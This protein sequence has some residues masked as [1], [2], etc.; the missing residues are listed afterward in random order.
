MTMILALALTL[1]APAAESAPQAPVAKTVAPAAAP[2]QTPDAEQAVPRT[3]PSEAEWKEQKQRV[4]GDSVVARMD[5]AQTQLASMPVEWVTGVAHGA[6]EAS[7]DHP[8][9]QVAEVAHLVDADKLWW[10][11]TDNAVAHYSKKHPY[12]DGRW[13]QQV[14]RSNYHLTH[15]GSDTRVSFWTKEIIVERGTHEE[16]T[17]WLVTVRDGRVVEAY[18]FTDNQYST[19]RVLVDFTWTEGELSRV[20]VTTV[21]DW[22]QGEAQ[23]VVYDRA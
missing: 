12:G 6:F 8:L 21:A 1:A 15:A 13:A 11:P 3:P 18:A 23:E 10:K 20:T 5:T 9:W 19:Q 14:W 17:D 4:G 22:T 2:Q 16:R 7:W